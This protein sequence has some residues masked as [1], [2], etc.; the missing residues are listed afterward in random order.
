MGK[1]LEKKAE[2]QIEQDRLRRKMID[3]LRGRTDSDSSKALL[4]DRSGSMAMHIGDRSSH[5]TRM[6]ELRKLVAAFPDV[7]KF[8]YD[9]EISELKPGEEISDARGDNDEVLAFNFV[10][11]A[12]VN[13]IVLLS[14]GG[15]DHPRAAL[16]A[17]RGLKVDVCYI[18]PEPMPQFLIDLARQSGT[19][20]HQG[21]LT[22]LKELTA[23]VKERLLLQESSTPGG[24]KGP[25]VL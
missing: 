10:K 2:R 7:R 5:S 13:H 22:M 1:E 4:L 6:Q 9:H 18:G 12:G 14:D 11:A 21:D 3:R 19:T 8:Q 23:T 15:A 25:I 17:A 16:Q 24:A 20:P